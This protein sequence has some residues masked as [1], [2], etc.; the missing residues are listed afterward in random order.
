LQKQDENLYKFAY[1]LSR[2][3]I[4]ISLNH[5]FFVSYYWDLLNGWANI[6]EIMDKRGKAK[7]LGLKNEQCAKHKKTS[8]ASHLLLYSLYEN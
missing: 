5:T 7:T 1:H 6:E 8:C 3:M 4:K 2:K